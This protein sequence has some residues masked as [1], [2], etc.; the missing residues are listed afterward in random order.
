[1]RPLPRRVAG[2][3]LLHLLP[4]V[5]AAQQG[6][7][8]SPLPPL[9]VSSAVAPE[10]VTVG[11]R[12]RSVLQVVV[13]A[14]ATVDFSPLAAGD[15]LQPVDSVRVIPGRSG[16][17]PIA[18]YSLVA[19]VAG[20]PLRAQAPVRVALPDGS[21]ATYLLPL[22]LPVVRSVLPADTAGVEPR[23]ARGLLAV[24]GAGRPLW[25]WIVALTA[26]LA[27][28]VAWLLRRRRP[29]VQEE[30]PTPRERALA[31][32][33]RI[34]AERGGRAEAD[35][36][37]AGATRALRRYVG[38]LEASWG[39]DLTT[40]E[41]LTTLGSEGVAPDVREELWRLLQHADGVK[42]ARYSPTAEEVEAFLAG[43]RRWVRAYP[44]AEGSLPGEREAA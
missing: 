35:V 1:M 17:P 30:E 27:A 13:P 38:E 9:P 43:A 21:A 2:L 26:L 19:W 42:F 3:G 32:L 40:R 15:T 29:Q 12:F 25:P 33:D 39:A 28:G 7:A 5:A 14:G 22:R 41:L 11:E 23:P 34:A 8:P 4:A 44:P 31:A 37:Y 16:E 6:P 18:S 24:P 36:L 10:T 20:A